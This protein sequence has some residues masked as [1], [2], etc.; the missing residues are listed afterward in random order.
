MLRVEEVEG[1]DDTRKTWFTETE[2]T[3]LWSSPG[4]LLYVMAVGL[5]FA[6]SGCI[7]SSLPALGTLT[8]TGLPH[9]VLTG[10]LLPSLITSGFVLSVNLLLETC[11]FLKM[12]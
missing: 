1:L 12:K 5:V 9:P 4:P 6:G 10:G 11:S 3:S 7:S 8:L 2:A